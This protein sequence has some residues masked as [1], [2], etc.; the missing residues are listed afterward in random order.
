MLLF[1]F[2][3]RLTPSVLVSKK[4][5]GALRTALKRSLWRTWAELR[6]DWK[7]RRYL[8]VERPQFAITRMKLMR[9]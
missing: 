9:R 5:M 4:D 3:T 7:R 6:D 2:N 8:R 1:P